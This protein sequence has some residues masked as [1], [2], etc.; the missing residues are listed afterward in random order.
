MISKHLISASWAVVI[1]SMTGCATT[2]ALQEDGKNQIYSGTIKHFE[3]GCAHAVCL[4]FPFSLIA[5]TVILPYTIPRTIYNYSKGN[6]A[7][8]KTDDKQNVDKSSK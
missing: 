8:K 6:D 3:L 7:Q 2:V 5:D 4:D 1:M